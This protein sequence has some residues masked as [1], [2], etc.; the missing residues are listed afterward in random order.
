VNESLDSSVDVIGGQ[1][2]QT[3]GRNDEV[4]AD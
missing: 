3:G 1:Q 4:D 2:L